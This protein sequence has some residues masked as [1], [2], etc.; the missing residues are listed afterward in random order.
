MPNTIHPASGTIEA[1]V[2][3]AT[4]V[5]WREILAPAIDTLR[6]M[7]GATEDEFLQIGSQ[8]QSFYQ[9]SV[10]ITSMA[11]QLQ[12]IV[13]GE[14]LQMLI[15]RLQ[16]M[17]CD[18]EQYLAGARTRSG[19]SFTTLEKVQ[20]LL[21]QLT[22]PLEGF[23]KMNKTLRMLSISTKIES[24]RLGEMGSGF[25]N[26]AMDVEKLSHQVNEKSATILNQRQ[27]LVSTIDSNLKYVHA[28]EKTQDADVQGAL[29]RT[30]ASLQELIDV[31]HRCAGFG[32]MVSEVSADVSANISEVVCSQQTHDITR[33]QVEHVF[34]A[35]EKLSVDLAAAESTAVG[36]ETGR[37]LV[38]EA[39]DVCELQEAQ[40]RF[41]T[42]E[43][44]TA[45]CTIVENLRDVASK[46]AAMAQETLTVA[47]VADSG[48]SSFVNDLKQGMSS[49]TSVL[50]SCAQS[51]RNISD[52]M[53]SV[54]ATI[55]QITGFVEDIEHIGSEI[56]LIALNSQIK[57]A[58]TGQEGA[59]LGVLAE[60]IKRL[61]D[62]AVRQTEA[63]TSTLTV[64][65]TTTKHLSTENEQEETESG[66]LIASMETELSGIIRT[67][68]GMN[69]D[70]FHLL[71]GLGENVHSL[72]A[73][74][75]QATA[76]ID[77]HDRIKSMADEVLGDL[78]RI[79]DQ[80]R[81]IEPA[82]SQFKQNLQH[83]EERYTMESERHIHEAIARK[84]AGHHAVST[85]VEKQ[86]TVESDSE[87]GDNIDL[88]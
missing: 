45:V 28:S 71:A 80:A 17:M 7:A 76:G 22:D 63:V 62:E 11:G 44:H 24:A 2:V 10:D 46:Q 86:A 19:E 12:D 83:M 21:E 13:S 53:Q 32:A 30:A 14:R 61:S 66:G 18:M 8:L 36:D 64:I 56:D 37:T 74:V 3:D 58:H 9:R 5:A 85:H 29:A 72:T 4:L 35:L 57:A 54:A 16:Q 38:V 87:F 79:V 42:T 49:I 48:G 60:A 39:G 6:L 47:G 81:Q 41:A 69:D 26:L 73:D 15:G 20:G 23:Q 40:L 82:S 52:T 50:V 68:G 33:Q 78:V 1:P 65:H 59:A 43:L 75:E 27:L 34:E 55:Q 51:D 25:V 84:R 77:V 31:T 88:F 70:L 67:L